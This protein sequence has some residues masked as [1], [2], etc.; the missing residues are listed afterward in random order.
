MKISAISKNRLLSVFFTSV[1]FAFSALLPAFAR[2]F[3]GLTWIFFP[4]HGKFKQN[5]LAELE[6]RRAER[7]EEEESET[8]DK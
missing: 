1:S 5:M 2:L 6:E 7:V 3:N 8:E 4:V